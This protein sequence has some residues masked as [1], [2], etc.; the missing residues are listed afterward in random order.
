MESP[1]PGPLSILLITTDQQR[2]DALG[3]DG[4]P[5][6]QT[7]CLDALARDPA[8]LFFTNAYA[9]A[10][11]C[12]PQRTAWMLGQHPLTCNQNRWREQTW[13][14]PETLS[15]ILAAQGFYC[16]VF[17]KRH[18]HPV[19]EPYGFHEFKIYESGRHGEDP[20]DYLRYL[21]EQTV[22]GGYSR[23]HGVGNNDV[24]AA[25][26]FLP[27]PEYPSS[28]IARESAGFLER[29]ARERA[30][31]PFFLWAS[32][33]KPHSP[34]DPPQPYD[35]LYRPQEMPAPFLPEG[36][37]DAELLPLQRAAQHYTWDTQGVEQMRAAR[38]MYYGLITHIDHCVG[39]LVQ[40]LERLGLRER[41]LI[42]FT[43]DHGD[44]MGDHH[45][46]FK[47]C[48]YE[49]SARVPYVWWIPPERRAA[50]GLQSC[51]RIASPVGV[52][53][54]GPSLLDLAGAEKP[55]TA[56]AVSLL[57]LL[58]GQ[59]D[60]A[61]SEVVGAY[62]AYQDEKHSAMLRWER[63]KYIYWQLGA[64]RQLFDLETDPAELHNLAEDPGHREL[65][66]RAH[67]RLEARLAEY[68]AGRSEVL[69][70]NGRL[71]GCAYTPRA[72]Y[73]PPIKGPW[74]RRPT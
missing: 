63:W 61:Q 66:A 6:I 64:I 1:K 11:V 10:P 43:S 47:A 48:Y 73:L 50:L 65:A 72:D 70:G 54:L 25:A 20:D 17:G 35:R 5:V 40:T 26:S 2:G 68:P 44:L 53:G 16:G 23:A 60:P 56:S 58:Q 14:T 67:A 34:Y 28:W 57:P 13:R 36:G 38:A 8:G 24:F 51:G 33:N 41:T 12:V 4:N 31:Q 27:E 30:G 52:S 32:F 22:W 29:H 74:G 62:D 49:G 3:V 7:R 21:R 59:A 19:R 39:R 55:A 45:L 69:D 42:A 9:E 18:F 37:L 15:G 46:Y 71:T